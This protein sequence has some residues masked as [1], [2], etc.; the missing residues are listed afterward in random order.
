MESS[1]L[2]QSGWISKSASKY[3][4]RIV[5]LNQN[6]LGFRADGDGE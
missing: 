3:R 4:F 1:H 2:A 5:S 6:E